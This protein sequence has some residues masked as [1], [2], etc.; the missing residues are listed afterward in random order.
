MLTCHD[1]GGLQIATGC[2]N[3]ANQVCKYIST[4]PRP[5]QSLPEECALGLPVKKHVLNVSQE[6][7]A[8]AGECN[9]YTFRMLLLL[10]SIMSGYRVQ[11]APFF[12]S[13]QVICTI[14]HLHIRTQVRWID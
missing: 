8:G 1:S 3:E 12:P 14:Q 11:V 2:I 10:L 5:A 7:P 6:S 4:V 13:L 9:L